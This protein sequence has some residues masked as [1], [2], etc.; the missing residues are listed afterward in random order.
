MVIWN[1]SSHSSHCPH[2]HSAQNAANLSSPAPDTPFSWT[3]IH[4]GSFPPL[5]TYANSCVRSMCYSHTA[6]FQQ[7]KLYHSS[8]IIVLSLNSHIFNPSVQVSQYTQSIYQFPNL[9]TV[10]YKSSQNFS[11][12]SPFNP[13]E[14]N[15]QD[16][17]ANT[18]E[19]Y[20]CTV[21]HT[22]PS[23]FHLLDTCNYT[24]YST[25]WYFSISF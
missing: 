12:S 20:H 15:P 1:A 17:R 18:S 9:F 6:P 3:I 23:S 10:L 2:S 8:F 24:I 14:L 21:P 22:F 25:P 13:W 7:K 4:L 11:L 5:C 16:S 19:V